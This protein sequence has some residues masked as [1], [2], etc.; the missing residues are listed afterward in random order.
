MN[1]TQGL[2]QAHDVS[3]PDAG[4]RPAAAS[5]SARATFITAA[6]V[7]LAALGAC[8]STPTPLPAMAVAQAAVSRADSPGTKAD[9]PAALAVATAKLEAAQVAFKGGDSNR[10]RQLAD[11]AALDAEVADMHAQAMRSQRAATDSRAA[12]S[13]LQQELARKSSMPPAQ[14]PAMPM[15]M[16]MPVP[17]AR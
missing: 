6:A 14:A 16:Q 13:V 8:A 12:A 3:Q 10:A 7:A 2:L 1:R 5:V 4:A 11:E 15:P 9:A 17:A